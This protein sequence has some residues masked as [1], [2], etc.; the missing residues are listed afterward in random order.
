MPIQVIEDYLR[1]KGVEYISPK[2]EVAE[3]TKNPFPEV[4]MSA[5]LETF[6]SNQYGGSKKVAL[7]YINRQ[8][9]EQYK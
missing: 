6:A 1:S 3:E 9:E 7:K 8:I 2:E 5:M 4:A